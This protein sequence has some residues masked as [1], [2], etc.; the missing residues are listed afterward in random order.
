M[1]A[2]EAASLLEE[3]RRKRAEGAFD[4]AHCL[5]V[6]ATAALRRRH[7]PRS[8]VL[9][10]ALLTVGLLEQDLGRLDAADQAMTRAMAIAVDA[11]A[12]MEIELGCRLVLAD[13]FRV[14]GRDAEAGDLLRAAIRQAERG[15]GPDTMMVA[16]ACNALARTADARFLVE[17]AIAVLDG[18]V[19]WDHPTLA[20]CRRLHELLTQ[21]IDRAHGAPD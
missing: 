3:A 14:Q 7:G 18:V 11:Q 13:L 17:R 1:R 21:G 4:D 9:V 5:A 10:L 15:V 20:K 2:A 6:E 12:G 8:I 19:E 16:E